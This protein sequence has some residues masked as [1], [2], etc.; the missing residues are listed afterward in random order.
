[1]HF[2]GEMVRFYLKNKELKSESVNLLNTIYNDFYMFLQICYKV[3]I[4]TS[5]DKLHE[6][7]NPISS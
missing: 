1:M 3:L 4:F 2:Q 6:C 7:Y 5:N